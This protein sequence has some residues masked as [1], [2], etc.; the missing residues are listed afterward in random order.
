[1]TTVFSPDGGF[2]T[3]AELRVEVVEKSTL[4]V[5]LPEGALLF[6]TLVN[7]ESVSVVREGDEYLFYVVPSTGAERVATVRI[8][9]AVAKSQ[10]GRIALRGPGLNV[11]LENVSWRVVIPPG[12]VLA[13][14]SGGL[15]LREDRQAGGF[16]LSDYQSLVVSKRAAEVK[17][18]NDFIAEANV[19]LQKGQQQQAG[20]VLSRASK[21]KGLDQATNEDARVQLRTLKTQQ[22][23]LGLNTLRQKIYLNNSVEGVKNEQLEQAANLNPFLQG[24]MNYDPRQADQLLMGNTAEENT[25]LRGIA[26]RIVDQQLAV[27]PAPSAIDVTLPEKGQVV[28]FTRSLQVDGGAPLELELDVATARRPGAGFGVVVLL[29]AGGIAA[30]FNRRRVAG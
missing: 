2:L 21:A 4:R 13:G 20:E 9:Y 22:A 23:V 25:A 8:V 15:Q 29:A 17:Q 18:A 11:P 5:R 10:D 3:S 7:G 1:L 19:L 28:T 14:H 16:G 6:N 12:Y 26:G 30:L 27:E 24:R